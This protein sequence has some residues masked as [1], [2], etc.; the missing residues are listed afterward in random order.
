MKFQNRGFIW[1]SPATLPLGQKAKTLAEATFAVSKIP[2]ALKHGEDARRARAALEVCDFET[3]IER[4]RCA[5]AAA[6]AEPRA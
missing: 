1:D 2:E 5:I 4:A 6:A 3:A